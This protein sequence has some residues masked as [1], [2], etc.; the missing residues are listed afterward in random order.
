MS[1]PAKRTI[2]TPGRFGDYGGRYV[3]ETLVAALE[4][5]ETGNDS[6]GESKICGSNE[7]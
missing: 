3:P 1:T 2:P 5:L 7:T 4:E 6:Y